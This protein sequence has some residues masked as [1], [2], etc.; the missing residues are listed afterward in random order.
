MPI[1]LICD[2]YQFLDRWNLLWTWKNKYYI[3]NLMFPSLR[4]AQKYIRHENKFLSSRKKNNNKI[5][6][7]PHL[8]SNKDIFSLMNF[9]YLK[10]YFP[11]NTYNGL[12]SYSLPHLLFSQHCVFF[13]V[14]RITKRLATEGGFQ[15]FYCITGRKREKSQTISK[16][17]RK[18]CKFFLQCCFYAQTVKLIR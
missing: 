10:I 9:L 15:F 18:L 13:S 14:L 17:S 6:N 7:F 11:Y 8:I 12:L 2:I 4:T 16:K 3:Q 1:H 5:K